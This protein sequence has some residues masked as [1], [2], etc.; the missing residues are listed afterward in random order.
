MTS[1]DQA[2]YV[3]EEHASEEHSFDELARGLARGSLSRRRALKLVGAALLGGVLSLAGLGADPDVAE[4][5][6]RRRRVPICP[7]QSC[8]CDCVHQPTVTFFGCRPIACPPDR[9]ECEAS[10]EAIAA[11]F[12]IP[13]EDVTGSARFTDNR[14]LEPGDTGLVLFCD[15]EQTCKVADCLVAT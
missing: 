12:G 8:C 11:R 14:D 7:E 4:A 2:R 5:R 1:E 13:P 15:A 3:R 10:C 6:R 9:A